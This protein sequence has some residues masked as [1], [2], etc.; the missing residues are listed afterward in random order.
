[1]VEYAS[2]VQHAG[3]EE[4]RAKER[5]IGCKSHVVNI[6]SQKVIKTYSK[7]AH[8][9]PKNPEAHHPESRDEVGI[10]CAIT[11]KE[12]SL[13]GHH[14]KFLDIQEAHNN[15]ILSK[16]P[17]A[18]VERPKHLKLDMTLFDDAQQEF[19]AEGY[20]MLH[21]VLP[22]LEKLH[23]NLTE[24]LHAPEYA[25]FSVAIQAGL[26]SIEEHYSCTEKSDAYII[27]SVLDPTQKMA[28]FDNE[29][30]EDAC[31][32]AWDL[33]REKFKSRYNSMYGANGT[34]PPT[35]KIS[36]KSTKM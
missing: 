30:D 12:S 8:F 18:E 29:W 11:V 35:A 5:E 19:S 15:K 13:A 14:Q 22:A 6:S 9:D 3:D 32:Q 31:V 36:K 24:C 28:W 23:S 16:D 33:V 20:P 7:T 25:P 34:P 17:N 4:F 27:C 26:N 10:I 2:L 21:L 1:M